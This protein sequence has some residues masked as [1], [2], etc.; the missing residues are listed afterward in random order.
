MKIFKKF[1]DWFANFLAKIG[2]VAS[3]FR[4]AGKFL[5]EHIRNG[6][7]IASF[8]VP[9]GITDVGLNHILNTEFD[10]GTQVTTWYIGLVDNA[11]FSAFAT[12]D[13]MASHAGWL[14]ATGYSESVRQTWGAGAAS[15]RSITNATAATFSINGSAT[16]KGVFITTNSTK[17]G[18]T[19][20]LWSTAAFASTVSVIN[21][22]SMK[23]TY[24]VSG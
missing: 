19:G 16:L 18:T 4:P 2:Q 11:S 24:T 13:T 9:N 20:T 23:I 5:V 10:A 12:A 3:D 22:D 8:L 21:G 7:V 14:E 15:A 6:V 17:S 1:R